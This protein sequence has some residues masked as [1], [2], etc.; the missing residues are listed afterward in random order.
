MKFLLI[1]AI[2]TT[3]VLS[4]TKST[5]YRELP[6]DGHMAKISLSG[7][8][9]DQPEFYSVVID[10]KKVSFFLV[11][12]NGEIQSY[13]NACARCYPKKMGF[14][15]EGGYMKC[16][17]CDAK[18]PSEALKEGIG[19]CSPIPLEG[20]QKKKTYIITREALLKGTRFF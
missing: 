1:S 7:I 5:P 18:Y 3:L 16:R 20:V 12:I 14:R 2:L 4:C 19:S 10:G 8:R 11:M 15:P 6:F 17:A 13:F 9:E